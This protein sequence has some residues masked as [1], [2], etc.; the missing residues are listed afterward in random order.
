MSP[1][2]LDLMLFYFGE[3]HY[4]SGASLNQAGTYEV[5]DHVCGHIIF[6]NNVVVNG[7]WSFNVASDEAVDLCEII[8]SKGKITFPFFNKPHEV[9]LK[10]E[11]GQHTKAF[12]HPEHISQLMVE[13]VVN[14]FN[15][16]Q[17]NNPCAIEDAIPLMDI[18]DAFAVQHGPL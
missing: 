8:G 10:N 18:M 16:D 14:Y 7:S 5:A 13:Q 12:K 2:Q 6:K 1:H 17:A 4:Y 9:T 11:T 15:G 3:P